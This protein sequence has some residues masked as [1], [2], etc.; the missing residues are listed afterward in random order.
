MA[1]ELVL[2]PEAERDISEAYDWYENRRHGLGEE[3]LG[4]VDDFRPDVFEHRCPGAVL[5]HHFRGQGHLRKISDQVEC[6]FGRSS[7]AFFETFVPFLAFWIGKDIGCASLNIKGNAHHV[8]MV[9][10]YQPVQRTAN[11]RR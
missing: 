3:F 11:R 8:R 9:C 4:C 2:A 1:A 7:T 6:S 5:R 10:D